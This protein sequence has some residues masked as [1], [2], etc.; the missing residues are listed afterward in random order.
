MHDTLSK[1]KDKQRILVLSNAGSREICLI[2]IHILK[3]IQKE[4]D[5]ILANGEEKID[6]APIVI[7]EGNDD[8]INGKARFLH[9]QHH[10]AVI[11]HIEGELPSSY[12][13]V[14]EYFQQFEML[15]SQTPKG[16]TLLFNREDNLATAIGHQEREDVR[17]IEF[18]DLEGKHTSLG[19]ETKTGVNIKTKNGNFASHAGAALGLLKRLGVTENQFMAGLKTFN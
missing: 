4:H 15:S 12:V 1:I 2:I 3:S 17:L 14:E 7:I 16:G 8:K 11:H 5:Y 9:F 19:F 10:V 6:D 13:T 18:S